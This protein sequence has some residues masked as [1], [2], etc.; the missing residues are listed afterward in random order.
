MLTDHFPRAASTLLGAGS[1]LSQ[2]LKK[3]RTVPQQQIFKPQ[4]SAPEVFKLWMEA[5][6]WYASSMHFCEK[7]I[8]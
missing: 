1:Y 6:G 4:I 5:Q 7:R 2:Q 3:I 8:T